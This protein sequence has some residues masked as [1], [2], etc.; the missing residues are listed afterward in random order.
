MD[1][2]REVVNLVG[3]MIHDGQKYAQPLQYAPLSRTA[4]EKAEL[5]LKS[6]NYGGAPLLK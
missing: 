5:L 4:Q 3:W 1:K 6:V 2:A